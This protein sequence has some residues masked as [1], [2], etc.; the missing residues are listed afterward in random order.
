MKKM[1][2]TRLV[3]WS[4]SLMLVLGTASIAEEP[5]VEPVPQHP[6]ASPDDARTHGLESLG[7]HIASTGGVPLPDLSGIVQDM[8]ALEALG[9]GAFWDMAMGSD[10]VQACASCHFHAGADPRT[11][12][13]LNPGGARVR[14]Q[15]HGVVR[16]YHGASGAPDD[17]FE[18][19]APD[20]ELTA[21]DFPFVRT[22]NAWI[23]NGDVNEPDTA[24]G[25]SND[26]ASSMGVF[27]SEYIGVTP[28][29]EI[30]DGTSMTD[31]VFNWGGVN[32]RRVEPRNTPTVINA[33]F[34]FANFWDG[35]ANNRFNGVTPFGD[36]DR[37]ARIY[38]D[39]NG[40]LKKRRLSLRN[41]S[42]ASQAVGPILSDFEMSHRGRNWPAVGRKMLDMRVLK[43][44]AISASDSVF[45]TT[46]GVS[47]HASGNG[48]DQ[49]YRDLIMAAFDEKY[50]VNNTETVEID[51]IEYSQAEAN[52]SMFFG[53]AVMK[54]EATLVSPNSPFDRW[55]EDSGDFVSGFG[56]DELDGLNVFTGDGKCVNCHS[57]PEFTNA[58]VRNY[59][60]GNNA[61]E[62]M[63][64]ADG[65]HALYDNG[66]YNIAV[67]LTTDDLGRGGSDPNGKPL[68]F[69]RQTVFQRLGLD[70]FKF[71]VIGEDRI[72]AVSE[73]GE[74]VCV[75]FTDDG[76]CQVFEPL[77]WQFKHVAAG[78]AFKASTIRNTE[79]N[80]PYFHNGGTATLRQLVEFYD[81][82]GN[83]CKFNL[84]DLDPDI[85]RLDLSEDQKSDLVAFLV[86]TTDDD[87]RHKRAPFDHPELVV[88]MGGSLG[89]EMNPIVLAPVG[90]GGVATPLGTFLGLDPHDN[91]AV[92]VPEDACN[93]LFPQE[94]EPAEAEPHAEEEVAEEEPHAEEE[95]V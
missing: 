3:A 40:D 37:K 26:I 45:S 28:G 22:P 95:V 18:M 56:Q 91:G 19:G 69:A 47:I 15:H 30:D 77:T 72:L 32:V 33:A 23:E 78:G 87:V 16:G 8:D 44:Q 54:Y 82:G 61:I 65:R 92:T 55:M 51:G 73:E 59:Q 60:N 36:Q 68:A 29:Y 50:W 58:S 76:E 7:N 38:V 62:P 39:K 67:T 10:G 90:A 85:R 63:Q 1:P 9:K 94:E 84:K 88:P 89:A 48:L 83:F 42:L 75:D 13:Q 5:E 17:S 4:G 52:F 70:W 79:L 80:G 93:H 6:I 74:A 24:A 49:T 41:A 81:R 12:N 34:N 46:S 11:R 2:V 43:K 53:L 27:L 14:D 35:R 64:M 86:S 66:F 57:G 31:S 71:E 21:A 25:N 20:S